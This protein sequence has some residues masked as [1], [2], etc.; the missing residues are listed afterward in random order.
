MP[1]QGGS[2]VE[3]TLMIANHSSVWMPSIPPPP[4]EAVQDCLD[5]GCGYCKHNSA[6]C[7]AVD[8]FVAAHG[9]YAIKIPITAQSHSV[10]LPTVRAVCTGA[11]AVQNG[12]DARFID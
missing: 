2:S 1:A 6:T 12:F 9:S 3:V 7:I 11:K 4:F 5:T 8:A 10:G